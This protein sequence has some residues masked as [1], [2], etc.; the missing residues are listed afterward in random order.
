[1]T[2]SFPT[3]HI[4]ASPLPGLTP[5]NQSGYGASLMGLDTWDFDTW[6]LPKRQEV[7]EWVTKICRSVG[8]CILGLKAS[9][10]SAPPRQRGQP[11]GLRRELELVGIGAHRGALLSRLAWGAASLGE[12]GQ[13]RGVRIVSAGQAGQL[14]PSTCRVTLGKPLLSVNG[15]FTPAP[16]EEIQADL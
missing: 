10:V 13:F 11:A 1:M 16:S 15:E 4:L 6:K 5:G 12:E 8:Q 2:E 7:G 3:R 14:L 9:L